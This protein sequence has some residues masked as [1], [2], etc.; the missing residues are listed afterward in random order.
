M[1]GILFN[2]DGGYGNETE[3]HIIFQC[4]ASVPEHEISVEPIVYRPPPRGKLSVYFVRAHVS[5]VCPTEFARKKATGGAIFLFILMV[6]AMCYFSVL[7][8]VFFIKDSNATI[9][10]S[11]FWIE[12]LNSI[13]AV[14]EFIFCR[15][16][17]L[18]SK[19]TYDN[20]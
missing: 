13:T 5:D 11:E 1:S 9:P 20:I 12:V 15:K 19:S 18:D 4:N 17:M 14:F 3:T 6:L 10:H 16:L 2:Y 8:I 7:T